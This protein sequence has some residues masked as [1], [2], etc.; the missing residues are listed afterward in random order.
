MKEHYE[1][2]LRQSKIAHE[3][4]LNSLS[5]RFSSLE[6]SDWSGREEEL[7]EE[8]RDIAEVVEDSLRDV[9]YYEEQL[10]M[11]NEKVK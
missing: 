8:L 3:L 4:I 7:V 5:D 11:E 2:R 9:T 10:K 1:K 6:K